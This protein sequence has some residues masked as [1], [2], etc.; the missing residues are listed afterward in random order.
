MTGTSSAASTD[1]GAAKS[2]ASV[3]VV[4]EPTE[5]LSRASC[6]SGYICLYAGL[7]G[8]GYTFRL[9]AGQYHPNFL[10]IACPVSEGC[11]NGDFDNDASSWHNNTTMKYCVSSHG[12]GNGSDNS[13]PA[14]TSGNFIN[15]WENAP[16][17]IGFIG[18]P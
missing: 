2:A 3:Q 5:G 6:L 18:C 1:V 17:S 11:T 16:S 4:S 7:N 14:G 9:R 13:M 12:H 10:L 15:G 8:T